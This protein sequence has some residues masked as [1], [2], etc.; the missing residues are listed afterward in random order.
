[1]TAQHRAEQIDRLRLN[2][3]F[4]AWCGLF[5]IDPDQLLAQV[6]EDFEGSQEILQHFRDFLQANLAL[7]EVHGEPPATIH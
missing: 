2:P 1:M 3:S 4:H 5:L 7:R 6:N